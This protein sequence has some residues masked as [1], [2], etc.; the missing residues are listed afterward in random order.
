MPL[1]RLSLEEFDY[2]GGTSEPAK[3]EARVNRSGNRMGSRRAEDL[4]PE[5]LQ[6][7]LSVG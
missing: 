1:P 2:A 4:S 7:L 5:E 6:A 3:P